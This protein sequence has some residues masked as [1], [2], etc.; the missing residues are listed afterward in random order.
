MAEIADQYGDVLQNIEFAI[1][2]VYR[3]DPTLLDAHVDAALEGLLREYQAEGRGRPAP[4]LR[5]SP[6]AQA[7]YAAAKTMCD[8]RLGRETVVNEEGVA[9]TPPRALT[10]EE[11]SACLKRLRRSGETWT[12]RAGRQGYLNFIN[13]FIA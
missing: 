10:L 6:P 11:M 4:V 7:V 13:R 1:A 12:K 8:W 9:Q 2:G 3:A 5:L